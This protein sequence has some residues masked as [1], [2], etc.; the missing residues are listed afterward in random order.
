MKYLL[1][2][3]LLVAGNQV[4][5]QEKLIDSLLFKL[6]NAGEDTGRINL[7]IKISYNL[8][9]RDPRKGITFGQQA[10]SL[11]E[12]LRW[13]KGKTEAYV[14][15]GINHAT[16]G[17]HDKAI[18]YYQKA[19]KHYKEQKDKNAIS[20]VEANLSLV[21][22]ARG[23]YP[24]AL[25]H[26][27]SA[28]SL[29]EQTGDIKGQGIILENIG[30]IYFEQKDYPKTKLYY[31]KALDNYTLQHNTEGMARLMGNLGIV[32]DAEGNY[33]QAL[34]YH[35]NALRLNTKANRKYSMQINH[36]NVGLVSL[37][38][39]KYDRA[40]RHQQMALELSKEIENSSSIAINLGNL[41]ETYYAMAVDSQYRDEH[42]QTHLEKAI[43]L[44]EQAVSLCKQ[45]HL[46]GPQIEFGEYLSDAYYQAGKYKR[47]FQTFK[48]HKALKDS[49]FSL[50][51]KMAITQLES[52]RELELRNKQIQIDKLKI[53]QKNNE[54]II[55]LISIVLLLLIIGIGIKTLY[56]YRKSNTALQQEKMKYLHLIETQVE[57][58]KKQA[59]VLKDIAHMQSHDVRGPVATILGLVQLFNFKDPSDPTN[60][61]VIEGIVQIIGKL[62]DAVQEVIQKE[63]KFYHI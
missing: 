32:V 62:D 59:D 15:L 10:L 19:L 28:L 52:R 25:K 61:V 51:N 31:S 44:L 33:D 34:K 7:L 56:S 36:A 48:E 50:Q 17:E 38:L 58:I 20:G 60:R 37:H 57:Q 2:L 46:T 43:D 63:N 4:Y 22:L 14:D 5:A 35:T 24:T 39:K 8:H 42:R 47:S 21:Y 49:V 40:L 29:K 6:S 16:L 53:Q 45:I 26:A 12:K 54:R 55:Y 9:N 41:G 3:F 27:F 13:E 30:T 1:T 11:S 23:E 18:Y